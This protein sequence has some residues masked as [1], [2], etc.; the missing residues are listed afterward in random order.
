M[1]ELSQFML[2]EN[3][4]VYKAPAVY[5]LK[6]DLWL[7]NGSGTNCNSQC[8]LSVCN[9]VVKFH[10]LNLIKFW[11]LCWVAQYLIRMA[12]KPTSFPWQ[13]RK[14]ICSS[15]ATNKKACFSQVLGFPVTVS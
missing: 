1:K 2:G 5:Y 8:Y 3:A 15:K 9:A 14:K 10:E 11:L 6:S 13:N 7:K 4:P 12:I